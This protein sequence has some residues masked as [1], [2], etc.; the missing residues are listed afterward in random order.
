[1]SDEIIEFL[2]NTIE[3]WDN[4]TF[5]NKEN[6]FWRERFLASLPKYDN[7]KNG[8]TIWAAFLYIPTRNFMEQ[9]PEN[10]IKTL[11]RCLNETK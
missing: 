1:M 2:R 10:H 6:R 3:L 9:T 7:A 11:E 8:A 5:A 4:S